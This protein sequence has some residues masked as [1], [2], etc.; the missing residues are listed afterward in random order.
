MQTVSI[1]D[2]SVLLH[3]MCC[4]TQSLPADGPVRPCPH[5]MYVSSNAT[6]DEPWFVDGSV[7]QVHVECYEDSV[8]Q[9]L[10]KK[11]RSSEFVLF[12]VSEPSPAGLEVYVVYRLAE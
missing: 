5:L 12:R 8:V 6:P 3:C 11:F 7:S 10:R 2:A 9:S 4:G 1:N